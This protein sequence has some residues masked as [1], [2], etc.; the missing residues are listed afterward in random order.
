MAANIAAELLKI[1]AV[2]LNPENPYTW[3]SGWRSPIYCDNRQALSFPELR[4][5]IKSQLAQ[6]I[7]ERFP[8]VEG[9]AGVATAGIP[10]G[11]LVA[12]ELGLPFIYIRS[13]PKGHGLTNQVEGRI[14]PGAAYVLVEDLI[15]TGG[16]VLAAAEGLEN[17]GGD[18]I[19]VVSVFSYGF[20]QADQA[21]EKAGIRYASLTNLEDLLQKAVEINYIQPADLDTIREWRK[22]PEQWRQNP[23]NN[24]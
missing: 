16:S 18:V 22:S 1:Q 10:H 5:E 9:I 17:A 20:P 14:T 8:S 7:R 3:A 4:S 15:S 13:K 24:S 11:A 12:D 6:L 23:V 21:F 2:K 19:G